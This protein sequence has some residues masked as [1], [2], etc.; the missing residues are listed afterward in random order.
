MTLSRLK[1]VS[2]IATSLLFL[3]LIGGLAAIVAR[4]VASP[5][6]LAVGL[7][8]GVT[9]GVLVIVSLQ[10]I[11]DHRQLLPAASAAHVHESLRRGP[12][13]GVF[14]LVVAISGFVAISLSGAGAYTRMFGSPAERAFTVIDT[15]WSGGR[16]GRRCHE[17][18]VEGV[19]WFASGGG[20]LCFDAPL[21]QGSTFVLRGRVSPFGMVV[22]DTNRNTSNKAFQ[23]TLE[24]SRR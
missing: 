2:L 22:S 7:A 8:Y 24:D 18:S 15:H 1:A 23:Q 16:H 4:V 3:N 11:V 21:P 12:F 5:L 17:H 10:L 20:V 14:F 13:V 19:F 6:A 9:T